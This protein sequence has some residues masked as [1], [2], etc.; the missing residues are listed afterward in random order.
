VSD[1]TLDDIMKYYWDMDSPKGFASAPG[2]KKEAESVKYTQDQENVLTAL[3]GFD[4]VF[5]T[6]AAGTGKSYVF[7]KFF[8]SPECRNRY[9]E[10]PILASTG[11]A[12]ILLGGRTFHSFFGLKNMQ[13]PIRRIIEEAT[14]SRFVQRGLREAECVA[15]D[16]ISMLSAETLDAA[17]QIAS[18]V[19]EDPNPWGGLRVLASGDFLQLPPISHAEQVA[20]W[21]FQGEV[22]KR[23][24]FRTALLREVVRSKEEDFVKVLHKIRKGIYDD[25]IFYFLRDRM[26]TAED[27]E[28]F[29]GTR[30]YPHRRSVDRINR[31]YLDELPGEPLVFET[32]YDGDERYFDRLGRNIPIPKDHLELK[33]GALVMVRINAFDLSYVN[34]SLGTIVEID[35]EGQWITLQ[36]LGGRRGEISF[37]K[38][39]FEWKNASGKVVAR[40]RNFPLT[41]AWASTIHKAQGATIDNVCVDLRGVWEN[42]QSYVG[43]S[44][45]RS[46]EGLKVMG[47]DEGSIRCDPSVVAYYDAL[48]DE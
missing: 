5:V 46:V 18:I 20:T 39:D 17:S 42:G 27:L 4:N 21:A 7:D 13:G 11:A 33:V 37:G 12:A 1:K 15:I 30:L 22:W 8:W 25:E 26:I 23:S 47:W 36:M 43:L 14:E 28:Q 41:L 16:E 6:G 32:T 38:Q 19:R 40:A 24:N 10:I 44:R 48:E 34:G 45:V 9:D 35:P 29:Q 3:R 31:K 2:H